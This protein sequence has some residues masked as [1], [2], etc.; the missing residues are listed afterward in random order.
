MMTDLP[1]IGQLLGKV[2]DVRL[3][4]P[5]EIEDAAPREGDDIARTSERF[6]IPAERQVRIVRLVRLSPFD[7]TRHARWVELRGDR[8]F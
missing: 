8:S 5:T 1:P 3:G 2:L 4:G 7:L 6:H